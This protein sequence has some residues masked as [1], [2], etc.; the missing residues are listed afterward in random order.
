MDLIMNTTEKIAEYSLFF[1]SS[2]CRL[3]SIEKKNSTIDESASLIVRK[4][5]FVLRN[6][7]V[8]S[9][10][11]NYGMSRIS[12]G[13]LTM[14]FV[15]EQQTNTENRDAKSKRTKHACLVFKVISTR[16]GDQGLTRRRS[17]P[18][19]I[20][21]CKPPPP[22]PFVNVHANVRTSRSSLSS[23]HVWNACNRPP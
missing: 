15:R 12:G 19:V 8:R 21:I 23:N 9:R 16:L 7:S 13:L 1:F 6:T 10:I 5:N 3:S 11:S 14:T 22:C 20:L 2:S 18:H 17:T 4:N